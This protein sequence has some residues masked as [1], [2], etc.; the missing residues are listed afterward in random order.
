VTGIV[1]A[2][3]KSRRLGRDKALLPLDGSTLIERIIGTISQA[4]DPILVI[5]NP[6]EKLSWLTV[7]VVSDR[8]PKRSALAGIYTGLSVSDTHHSLFVACDLP[9]VSVDLLRLLI[10]LS[11]GYDVVIPQSEGGY[12]PLCAVYSRNC[13]D[14]IRSQLEQDNLRVQAFFPEVRV[15]VVDQELLRPYDP[16][17]RAFFNINTEEEYQQALQWLV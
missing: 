13:L 11:D 8:V 7:P 9:F 15:K 1:L 12:E 16:E 10:D 14:P 6:P 4:T 17:G 2:G 3:G 5:S